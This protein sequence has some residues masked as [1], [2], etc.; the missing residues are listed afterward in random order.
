MKPTVSKQAP[1]AAALSLLGALTLAA[2]AALAQSTQ[3][4]PPAARISDQAIQ[5][6]QQAYETLQGRIKGLND[7]GRPVRDY[8]L[9]KAQCWLDVSFHEY[10]RNDRGPFPQAAMTE[11]EK[12]IVGMEKGTALGND[13]P[14]VGEAVKLR[15]DLWERAERLKNSN[16]LRCAAQKLACA[17]VELVH[18]GNEHAQQQ[19][20][21]AKPYVQIAEDLMSEAELLAKNC[22]GAVSPDVVE[23]R[24]PPPPP[25]TPP[26]AL[27]PL[28]EVS[29]AAHVV[30][31]FDR[32]LETDIRSHS[33]D[34]LRVLAD[35]VKRAGLQLESIKLTGHADRLNGTGKSD[36]N[37]RL[38]ERRVATVKAVLV[39]LGIDEKLIVT[40]ARGDEQQVEACK[41]NFRSQAELQECLLPNR[42]VEVEITA[43]A[44]N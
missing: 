23:V 3:L 15:P 21:H 30:F 12:L 36:Y 38:S 24:Q 4:N 41:S 22:P 16:G 2:P 9:S 27:P 7:K 13:T 20:R 44:R 40:G 43:K 33:M 11:S 31:S 10:T 19:W 37:Q 6:D 25:V 42:R 35:R 39:R 29:V 34:Q 14:L 26:P 32:Y 8:H 17:E 1:W 5:A 28:R 18:A